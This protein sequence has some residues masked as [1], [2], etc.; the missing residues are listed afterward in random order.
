MAT[1]RNAFVICDG[2]VGPTLN[3]SGGRRVTAGQTGCGT[4]Q[5]REGAVQ[6]AACRLPRAPPARRTSSAG[7]SPKEH[8]VPNHLPAMAARAAV[9]TTAA[10]A[11]TLLGV[12]PATAVAAP[13]APVAMAVTP[14]VKTAP[15]PA[16]FTEPAVSAAVPAPAAA[17]RAAAV[18]IAISKVGSPYRYGATGPNAFDCSGLVSFAFK[19]AGVSLPRTSRAQSQ[20]GTPV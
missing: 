6:H 15:A 9:V 7:A 11:A 8:P 16:A 19:K 4:A 2:P 14:V 18:D 1:H 13:S 12:L 10:A 20:V 5:M 17:A 3:R